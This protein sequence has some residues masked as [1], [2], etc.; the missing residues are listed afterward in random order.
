ML[1][2]MGKKF[3]GRYMRRQAGPDTARTLHHIIFRSIEKKRIFDDD[4]K[5]ERV[6]TSHMGKM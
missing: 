5:R 4:L 3:G 1:L 6:V 2:K